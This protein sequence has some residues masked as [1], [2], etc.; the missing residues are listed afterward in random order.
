MYLDSEGLNVVGTIGTAGEVRQ[1]ELDL[2]PAIVQSHGHRTDEGL[3][4]CRALVVAGPEAPPYILVIQHLRNT[5]AKH[6]VK[7][8]IEW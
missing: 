2:V 8:F 5:Q 3:H 7:H 6:L 1:V 4:P